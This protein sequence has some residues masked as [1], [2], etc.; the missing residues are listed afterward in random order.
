MNK[1]DLSS[2]LQKYREN[3]ATLLLAIAT[4]ILPQAAFAEPVADPTTGT[5][6]TQT[7]NQF[8]I[9][10][11][12]QAGDNLFHSFEKFGLTKEQTANFL[13][14]PDIANILGRV[15]GG[16]ASFINGLIQVTGGDS[17]LFLINPAGLIFGNDASLNL[18][19]SFTATTADGIQI[20][21]FWF[22]AL[23]ENDYSNLFAEPNGFA[24]TSDEAGTIINSSNLSV[25]SGETI[26]LVGGL[27]INTGTID[28]PAGK[29]E[30]AAVEGEQ[31]VTITPEGSLLSL[32]LP[33][34]AQEFGSAA[35]TP[36]DLPTL[37]AGGGESA[38]TGVELLEDGSIKLTATDTTVAA[39]PGTIANSG[40][41]NAE[42]VNTLGNNVI[43]VEA[44]SNNALDDTVVDTDEIQSAEE[45]ETS[46]GSSE[47]GEEIENE[48]A[49]IEETESE[50]VSED[51]VQEESVDSGEDT[52]SENEK[53]E[54]AD[55]EEGEIENSEEIA[56]EDTDLDLPEEEVTDELEDPEAD[57]ELINGEETENEELDRS[58]PDE[59]LTASGSESI[60]GDGSTTTSITENSEDANILDIAGETEVDNKLLHNFVR[61]D[62]EVDKTANF[63]STAGIES[64]LASVTGDDVSQIDG[65][66]TVSGADS[67]LFLIN[68]SGIIF[69]EGATLNLPGSFVANASS[70]FIGENNLLGDIDNA[71]EITV[72]DGKA[73]A[74]I[75][76]S[77]TNTGSLNASNGSIKVTAQ[78]GFLAGNVD[79]G[80]EGTLTINPAVIEVVSADDA[81][82]ANSE[83][84]AEDG[85]SNEV[86]S[87][88]ADLL[89]NG[90]VILEATDKVTFDTSV[91]VE[92]LTATVTPSEGEL[93]SV[94]ILESLRGNSV[95]I[96][97][98]NGDINVNN[99]LGATNDLKLESINGNINLGNSENP[100][101]ILVGLLPEEVSSG[102]PLTIPEKEGSAEIIASQ[103]NVELFGNITIGQNS[104]LSIDAV[105]FRA[106]QPSISRTAVTDADLSFGDA[107]TPKIL[108]VIKDENENGSILV[109][110]DNNVLL[111]N[112]SNSKAVIGRISLEELA[113]LGIS[114][115]SDS[116]RS[117]TVETDGNGEIIAA[118]DIVDGVPNGVPIDVNQ[119]G[120]GLTT[121]SFLGQDTEPYNLAV[122]YF[123]NNGSGIS[124]LQPNV[125]FLLQFQPPGA[126][127]ASS[128]D[129]CVILSADTRN[130]EVD[131]DNF[132]ADAEINILLRNE[133]ASFSIGEEL[134]SNSVSGVEGAISILPI[135]NTNGSQIT[136]NIA[137]AN[138]SF[139][140]GG[141]TDIDD[142]DS[143]NGGT[144]GA[145]TA[146][147]STP[148][149]DSG[150][151]TGEGTPGTDSSISNGT[152]A[153]GGTPGTNDDADSGTTAN[154]RDGTDGGTDSENV[155]DG[156]ID[157]SDGDGVTDGVTGSIDSDG[158]ADGDNPGGVDTEGDGIADDGT[159]GIDSDND[160]IADG[161]TSGIDT[162][163]DGGGI[164]DD[165][166]TEGVDTDG[167]GI[168][169]EGTDSDGD[170]VADNTS[171]TDRD[172]I[173]EGAPLPEGNPSGID[174]DVDGD[175]IADGGNPSGVDTD[176][177]GIPEDG[178]T[179]GVDTDGD[180]IVDGGTTGI[181]SDGD[182]IADEGIDS[183]GDGVADNTSNTDRDTIAEG[184]PLPDGDS[185]SET[186]SD[187]DSNNGDIAD[188]GSINGDAD[189]GVDLD[190]N[191][192]DSDSDTLSTDDREDPETD[193]VEDNIASGER[194]L[195]LAT[196]CGTE[197]KVTPIAGTDKVRAKC[198]GQALAYVFRQ[199]KDELG[200]PIPIN[201]EQFPELLTGDEFVEFDGNTSWFFYQPT[202][203]AGKAIKFSLNFAR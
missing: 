122:A 57:A 68:P 184:A 13:S 61:F 89:S 83:I 108:R 99:D 76:D 54:T 24:F 38:A 63:V 162:D 156:G 2:A 147:G 152:S 160:G 119:F 132:D 48:T 141:E 129:T 123:V 53:Q 16:N 164:P 40:H 11:G 168:A 140:L 8:D 35:L 125:R 22:D 88:S 56:E 25:N 182:G 185:D 43:G 202:N 107:N 120:S 172:T 79:I 111:A 21:D 27:V 165:G 64:I 136:D 154:G 104:N 187:R 58:N 97:N 145:N 191:N 153:G 66:I 55:V 113:E 134:T 46:E 110:R 144:D 82:S 12:T 95:Q 148:E 41:L 26:S 85:E 115:P 201:K 70:G 131:L 192:P 52:A 124:N 65:D 29:I 103:G 127:S 4:A 138:G 137:F 31:L 62:V 45:K 170:G 158:D 193:D 161:D 169:D 199:P 176:G 94:Q 44:G 14:N 135:T 15:T 167:N 80:Q 42:E 118:Q 180:G 47:N 33:T 188:D 30:I 151:T 96:T 143:I 198:V 179:G 49:A 9:D 51:S 149:T 37:L 87:V 23:G 20:G 98:N 133:D 117:V 105:D 157:S 19:A 109:D 195:L 175:N 114:L 181:D 6:V 18:P 183:E 203:K 197:L 91:Q 7:G 84:S 196:F 74:F 86:F 69:G 73:I 10:G 146:E 121:D 34:D 189:D 75:G 163:V 71:G 1:F 142:G 17:N 90:N 159:T 173:A 186:N 130:S 77:V 3:L 177:D 93:G 166:T 100:T 92:N 112:V 59:T 106:E 39:Q 116:L 174:T 200:N 128:C 178:T 155:A 72:P 102:S 78:S 126:T 60:V 50:T 194:D 28:A 171:N 101:E 32:A 5:N 139:S 81:E 150:N 36:A 190:N 67:S